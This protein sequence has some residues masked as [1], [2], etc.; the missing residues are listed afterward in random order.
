MRISQKAKRIDSMAVFPYSDGMYASLKRKDK[1][2]VEYYLGYRND[3]DE[4]LV[5][6][7][8]VK[9]WDI[10]ARI[11][12]KM[13]AVYT[14]TSD[15]RNDDQRRC[16]TEALNL[17][18]DD[19]SFGLKA[20]TGWGKSYTCGRVVVELGQKTLIIIPKTD[21]FKSWKKN[22]SQLLGVPLDK[23]GH[24]QAD[25]V[26]WRGKDIVIATV[27]TVIK[28]D[29]LG[30]EF[31][32]YFGCLLLDEAHRMAAETFSLACRLF[33]AKYRFMTSATPKRSDGRISVLTAHIGP[34]MVEGKDIPMSPKI[35]I[36]KTKWR[37]PKYDSEGKEVYFRQ[38][39]T[40]TILRV[41]E[42]AYERNTEIIKFARMCHKNDRNHVMMADTLS[43]LKIIYKLLLDAGISARDIG[44]YIGGKT[45]VELDI[46]AHK[47]IILATYLKCKEGTDY[48]HWDALTMLS[49]KASA[50]QAVGRICRILDGKKQPVVLELVDNN[51]FLQGFHRARLK[52]YFQIGAELIYMNGE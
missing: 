18:R 4:L 47:K 52:E 23:I 19:V 48:P 46:A 34:V 42:E 25:T 33:P 41:L 32:Q 17:L 22:L 20:P 51:V 40:A 12:H 30:P 13:S 26:E 39:R 2:G 50:E 14:P 16:G 36:F 37:V 3:R 8:L 49:P 5:P 21:L 31:Y 43:Q 29:K 10:D 35:L 38:G 15:Y 44:W 9:R 28:F 24:V 1:N 6:R 27:Q 11:T 45:D 7:N